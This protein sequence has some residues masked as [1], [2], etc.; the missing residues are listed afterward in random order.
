MSNIENLP[1]VSNQPAEVGVPHSGNAGIDFPVVEGLAPIS[2]EVVNNTKAPD[3]VTEGLGAQ[4]SVSVGEK[5]TW[6]QARRDQ[7]ITNAALKRKSEQLVEAPRKSKKPLWIG[8]GATAAGL[9]LAAGA[10]LGL[11]GTKGGNKTD[12]LPPEP[13]TTTSAAATPGQQEKSPVATEVA[14]PRPAALELKK[15]M[16]NEE[17]AKTV[18][19]IMS[20]WGMAGANEDLYKEMRTTDH[21]TKYGVTKA[22]NM[23]FAADVAART[24]DVYIKKLLGD[25]YDSTNPAIAKLIHDLKQDHAGNL[26]NFIVT[27]PAY[28]SNVRPGDPPVELSAYQPWNQKFEYLKVESV[29]DNNGLTTIAITA[30]DAD[31][32]NKNDVGSTY[33]GPTDHNM[34]VTATFRDG[35]KSKL[36]SLTV[37]AK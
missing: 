1:P 32:R 15:D 24:D 17:A 33:P 5:A 23:R 37:V 12:T 25:N 35:D 21:M 28:Y 3:T 13:T 22:D 6:D 20:E 9:A 27:A 29:T 34:L 14:T 11:N 16:T 8:L 19:G 30:N 18:V 4:D 10:A 2:E 36:T 31:N 26:F 7:A